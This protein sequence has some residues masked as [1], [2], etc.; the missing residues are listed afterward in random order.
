MAQQLP[1]SPKPYL[2][3]PY[4]QVYQFA[5]K[6]LNHHMVLYNVCASTFQAST[7]WILLTTQESLTPILQTS[8]LRP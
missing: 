2:P 5:P 8:R 7:V 1:S 3:K 4:T 6:G